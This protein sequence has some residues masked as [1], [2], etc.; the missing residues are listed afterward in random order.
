M[1]CPKSWNFLFSVRTTPPLCSCGRRAKRLLVSKPGPNQGRTFFSCSIKKS[2]ANRLKTGC[3]FFKWDEPNQGQSPNFSNSKSF[4]ANN[5]LSKTVLSTGSKSFTTIPSTKVTLFQS[6][7]PKQVN[8]VNLPKTVAEKSVT[9]PVS[10]PFQKNTDKTK[11]EIPTVSNSDQCSSESSVSN[12]PKQNSDSIYEK[13]STKSKDL[14][15]L[16]KENTDKQNDM[17][18]RRS[19]PISRSASTFSANQNVVKFSNSKSLSNLSDSDSKK[20]DILRPT[21]GPAKRSTVGLLQHP[22][23]DVKTPEMKRARL[24]FNS[25]RLKRSTGCVARQYFGNV[26]LGTIWFRFLS[27]LISNRSFFKQY[28]RG[29]LCISNSTYMRKSTFYIVCTRGS[30]TALVEKWRKNF[31]GQGLGVTPKCWLTPKSWLLLTIFL[32]GPATVDKFSLF[33]YVSLCDPLVCLI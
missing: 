15:S 20:S 33:F 29:L 5:T 26:P 4:G 25:P 30:H 12:L 9:N 18:S 8:V 21:L 32:I 11:D 3:N 17:H 14:L 27:F 16:P 24:N 10:V 6:N 19:L 22:S 7:L 28:L 13:A 2:E 31:D 23:V 1:L